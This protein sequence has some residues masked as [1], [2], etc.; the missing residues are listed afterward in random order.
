[1]TRDLYKGI[2]WRNTFLGK[3]T[4]RQSHL[5]H[6]P[7]EEATLSIYKY[8]PGS[9]FTYWLTQTLLQGKALIPMHAT[10]KFICCFS[11]PCP[12]R[13]WCPLLQAWTWSHTGVLRDDTRAT[14]KCPVKQ[15][16]HKWKGGLRLIPP[17]CY[18]WTNHGTVGQP[19]IPR[20]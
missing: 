18:P 8:S 10:I 6:Q 14:Y 16:K 11:S 15:I 13:R 19:L 20:H 2:M 9:R 12:G 4:R 5:L 7:W 17:W 1:M 3:I